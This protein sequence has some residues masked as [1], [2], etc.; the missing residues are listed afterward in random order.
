MLPHKRRSSPA[1]AGAHRGLGVHR[2]SLS[3]QLPIFWGDSGATGAH[4]CRTI[5]NAGALY[6]YFRSSGPAAPV[7]VCCGDFARVLGPGV[8]FPAHM[9][10]VLLDRLRRQRARHGVVQRRQWHAGCACRW[11]EEW[12]QPAA[13]YR[14]VRYADTG[15]RRRAGLRCHGRRTAVTAHRGEG[16]GRENAARGLSGFHRLPE[17]WRGLPRCRCCGPLPA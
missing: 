6:A 3:R 8:T 2:A 17:P 15:R 13:A 4:S 14:A 16:R 7:R 9:T 10:A 5:K 11:C 1:L 12:R